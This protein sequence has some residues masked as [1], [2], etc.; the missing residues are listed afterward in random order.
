VLARLSIG[1]RLG[2][3]FVLLATLTLLTGIAGLWAAHSEASTASKVRAT[4]ALLT[5]VD[6][7][8][9]YIAD[10]TGWQ[11]FIAMDAIAEGAT[12][13]LA[14]TEVNEAGFVADKTAI[15]SLLDHWHG[16][17]MT[18]TEAQTFDGLRTLWDN[19]FSGADKVEQ[20]WRQGTHAAWV[21]AYN[22]MNTG[23]NSTAYS[24]VVDQTGH[25]QKSISARLASLQKSQKSTASSADVLIG[26]VIGLS[27]LIA[28]IAAVIVTRSVVGPVRRCVE[29]LR[30]VTSGD[31]TARADVVG[32]DEVAELGAELN[33]STE[34]TAEAV[35][36]MTRTAAELE[37]T[38]RALSDASLQ[39]LSAS[40]TA[41]DECAAAAGEGAEVS[42]NLQGI[43]AGTEQMRSAIDEIARNAS[44]AAEVARAGVSSAQEM[45][46]VMTELGATSAEIT[47]VVQLIATIANQTNLL[48]L[49]ATIEAARAGE[50]GK[51]FAVVAGEVKELA[52]QTADATNGITQRVAA[53]QSAVDGA[54]SAIDRVGSVIGE[55][56][57]FQTTI[58]SAVEEQTATTA[59]MG[60]T[61]AVA[62]AGAD[63]VSGS[64]HAASAASASTSQSIEQ[65][66]EVAVNLLS[67]SAQ[68]NERT[69]RFRV[70]D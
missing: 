58:A 34:T 11:A 39:L 68:L 30:R 9:F 52:Q 32:T 36:S 40:R 1:R 21:A 66:G 45:G 19:Y 51:G 49:N 63:T 44:Q 55:I 26:V 23:F 10:E 17:A 59:A 13:A 50:A 43:A 12:K 64:V 22:A 7:M 24:A 8:Q 53:M 65:V 2:A 15:Y 4:T 29:T 18:P 27:V 41:A 28:A 46:E 69:A 16:A 60:T 33:R 38:T 48:A 62:S 56:S 47:S 25:L 57:D 54:V 67:L 61:V 37:A 35:A 20:L 5:D 14:P 42:S 31:L 70:A 3:A 6:R